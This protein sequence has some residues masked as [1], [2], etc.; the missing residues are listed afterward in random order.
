[1]Y[2]CRSRYSLLS[3][4]LFCSVVPAEAGIQPF[5]INTINAPSHRI[6]HQQFPS[7]S[8]VVPVFRSCRSRGGGNPAL[9]YKHYPHTIITPSHRIPHLSFPLF[10]PIVPVILFCRSRG[11]GNPALPPLNPNF[12]TNPP[13]QD[14]PFLSYSVSILCSISS[15]VF[16]P[17][18]PHVYH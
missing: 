4:P 1:M 16:L 15:S 5:I 7:F 9:H 18:T 2:E 10:S 6:P 13:N 12:Q 3:F 17:I 14:S 8:P 11:G